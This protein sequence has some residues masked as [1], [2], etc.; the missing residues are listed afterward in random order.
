MAVIVQYFAINTLTAVH[1]PLVRAY[2]RS[3]ILIILLFFQH[4][5]R[6]EFFDG[7]AFK[8]L[9]IAVTQDATNF[10]ERQEAYSKTL[11]RILIGLT[12]LLMAVLG[13]TLLMAIHPI[14]HLKQ[15]I[16]ALQNHSINK[17]EHQYPQELESVKRQLNRLITNEQQTA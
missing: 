12:L 3:K 5:I 13:I 1:A 10:L 16:K 14:S 7:E 2:F 6:V 15:Q 11:N 8:P 4:H 17:I 9:T